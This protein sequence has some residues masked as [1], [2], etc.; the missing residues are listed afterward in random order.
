MCE[1]SGSRSYCEGGFFGRV[2]QGLQAL[3]VQA[4]S[5]PEVVDVQP[6]LHPSLAIGN[7][8]EVPLC[9][10][11]GAAVRGQPQLILLT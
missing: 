11:I 10:P 6:V 3:A 8:E 5:L 2:Q 4:V 9:V 7:A 1:T